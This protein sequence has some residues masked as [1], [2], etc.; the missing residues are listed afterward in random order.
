MRGE[1]G[2]VI[3]QN[4]QAYK[5]PLN[6]PSQGEMTI[7]PPLTRGGWEGFIVTSVHAASSALQARVIGNYN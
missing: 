5:N 2:M 7:T 6:P 1:G 3:V 4:T